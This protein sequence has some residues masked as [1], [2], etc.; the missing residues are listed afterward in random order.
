MEE[1]RDACPDLVGGFREEVEW[2]TEKLMQELE[3]Q[4]KLDVKV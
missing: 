1:Y 3:D 4:F 2:L